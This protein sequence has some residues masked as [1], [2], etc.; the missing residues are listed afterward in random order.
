MARVPQSAERDQLRGE[1]GEA[2]RAAYSACHVQRR[3]PSKLSI[4]RSFAG[5]GPSEATLYRW[6]D[7]A[8]KRVAAAAAAEVA[9]ATERH[10][11]ALEVRHA[12][13]VKELRRVRCQR[14]VAV[15][16]LDG[17]LRAAA[18]LPETNR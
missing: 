11:T 10:E 5:R 9:G 17:L 8:M 7:A 6:V 3:R 16:T 18:T 1:V 15:A 14:D 12:A 2:V 13:L 4:A